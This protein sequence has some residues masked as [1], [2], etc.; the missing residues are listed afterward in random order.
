[1]IVV[2]KKLPAVA[3]DKVKILGPDWSQNFKD[4]H[5]G[6]EEF[7]LCMYTKNNMVVIKLTFKNWRDSIVYTISI[8]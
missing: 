6:N 7:D 4:Q 5:G 8:Y 2:C 1:M 3:C